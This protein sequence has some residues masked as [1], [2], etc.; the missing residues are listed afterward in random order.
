VPVE[1]ISAINTVPAAMEVAAGGRRFA[2]D[3]E[4]TRSHARALDAAGFDWTLIE[5]G[6]Q[7]PDSEQ[8]AQLIV[9]STE[10]LKPMVAHR[11]G[12]VFPTKAARALATLDQ[13]AQGRLG[14]HIISG[15][16]DTEQRR[17]GDYLTKAERYDRS[18]E[19]IEI[20]RRV[21]TEEGP[22]SH[23]GA[24][25]RFEG[26]QSEVRPF[27]DAIPVS[28]G[29]SSEDA[30]RVGGRQGDIFGLWGE[31]LADTAQ[32]ISSVHAAATAAGRPRPRIWVSFRPIVA[33]T[34]E[35]AWEKAHA[36]LATVQKSTA[37][38]VQAPAARAEHLTQPPQNVG[39]QRLLAVA[40]RGE[41]HDR[42]LWTPV[43]SATNASGS[44]TALVGSYET[45]AQALL[46]YVD[47]GC[48]LLS[49]RGFDPLHD[50]IDYGRNLLPLVRQELAHRTSGAAVA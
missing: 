26:F 30:Y 16:N 48:E 50:A 6:S 35:L 46:D 13:I 7:T 14:V 45:V 22:V 32:Q 8:I 12:L 44:T 1:F 25:Y 3:V 23:E 17:E 42:A 4:Y 2:L 9:T 27:Q 38:L 29:G 33:A 41:L 19:Y 5:Y 28:V 15:G 43:V 40:A 49:I 47:I 31:P 34:D 24:F 18:E 10:R 20:L 21:W 37:A 39:S 11:P 36:V